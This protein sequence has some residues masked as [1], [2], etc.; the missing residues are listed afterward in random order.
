MAIRILRFGHR[1]FRDARASTH[2]AL[3]A[4]ALG[5]DGIVFEGEKDEKM[6]DS[7]R[8]VVKAWGGPFDVEHAANWK[9]YVEDYKKKGGCFVHLTMYGMPLQDVIS[10][11]RKKSKDC[12]VLVGSQK[13]PIEAYRMAD[14]NI[15]VTHQPHSEI[16]ALA[17]FL[18]R[19]FEGRELEKKWAGKNRISPSKIG[20]DVVLWDKS[21]GV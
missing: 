5:A 7:V 20:K 14:F 10:D 16:A 12:L 21:A 3:T 11:A 6:M 8:A 17:V 13:V 4:R 15:A 1:L 2:V 19:Y 18:D 9:R